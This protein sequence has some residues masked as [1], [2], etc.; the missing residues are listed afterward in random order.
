MDWEGCG[1]QRSWT[2]LGQSNEICREDLRKSAEAWV[3]IV[4]C[5]MELE[6]DNF[7][8]ETAH[9]YCEDDCGV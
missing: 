6:A 9:P 3:W 4:G 5:S 1:M 8:C 7:S 2:N